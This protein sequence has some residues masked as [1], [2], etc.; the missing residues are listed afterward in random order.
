MS[1]TRV[2]GSGYQKSFIEQNNTRY[3]VCVPYDGDD[4]DFIA[5]M[6]ML[7]IFGGVFLIAGLVFLSCWCHDRAHKRTF[8]I[9]ASTTELT[10]V[11]RILGPSPGRWDYFADRGGYLHRIARILQAEHFVPEEVLVYLDETHDALFKPHEVVQAMHFLFKK[12]AEVEKIPMV[13]CVDK[14]KDELLDKCGGEFGQQI[15]AKLR[16]TALS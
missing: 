4:P 9:E 12:Q 2:C 14:W 13:E 5:G 1:S 16:E 6:V 7:G 15:V 11:P 3:V 10:P 8:D